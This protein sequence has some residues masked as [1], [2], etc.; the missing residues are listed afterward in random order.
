MTW[1]G[2]DIALEPGEP[3]YCKDVGMKEKHVK[4]VKAFL[5]NHRFETY[6][7]GSSGH[8]V[9]VVKGVVHDFTTTPR[10]GYNVRDVRAWHPSSRHT[11]T[12]GKP[13]LQF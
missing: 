2:T 7:V 1:T 8:I 13:K 4:E 3:F 10:H 11:W 6:L 5:H 9:L 12:V